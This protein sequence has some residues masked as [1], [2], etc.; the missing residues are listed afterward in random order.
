MFDK[1]TDLSRSLPNFTKWKAAQSFFLLISVLVKGIFK[2]HDDKIVVNYS[3][4]TFCF[5]KPS[6]M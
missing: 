4:N 2:N 6:F 5:N 3:A 1:I